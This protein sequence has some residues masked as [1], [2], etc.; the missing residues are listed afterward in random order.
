MSSIS[1]L[2]IHTF[3]VPVKVFGL[4]YSVVAVL[5]FSGV[6]RTITARLPVR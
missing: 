5:L 6:I 2:K 1:M 4:P 3:F